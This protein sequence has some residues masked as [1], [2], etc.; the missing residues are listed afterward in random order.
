MKYIISNKFDSPLLYTYKIMCVSITN[1]M[2]ITLTEG[3][4]ACPAVSASG[5]VALAA[6]VWSLWPPAH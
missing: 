2:D 6:Y 4:V 3:A 5:V 1:W